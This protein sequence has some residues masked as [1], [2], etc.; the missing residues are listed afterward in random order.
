[1]FRSEYLNTKAELDVQMN[2]TKFNDLLYCKYRQTRLGPQN[3]FSKCISVCSVSTLKEQFKRKR[4][5]VA[6]NQY[7]LTKQRLGYYDTDRH[8]Q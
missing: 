8:R 5:T 4:R 6:G 3:G 2:D 1:M 7:K